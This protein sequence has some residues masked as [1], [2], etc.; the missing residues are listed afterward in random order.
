MADE[1]EK[2]PEHLKKGDFESRYMFILNKLLRK[3]RLFYPFIKNFDHFYNQTY[4][5]EQEF[6]YPT[7]KLA[8]EWIK[9]TN[10][11]KNWKVIKE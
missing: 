5:K 9:K 6:W 1:W 7:M 8:T 3:E 10:C 2:W 11:T 4:V